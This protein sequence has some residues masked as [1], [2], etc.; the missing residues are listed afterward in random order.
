MRD[1]IRLVAQIAVTTE[2]IRYVTEHFIQTT[3][4]KRNAT[5]PMLFQMTDPQRSPVRVSLMHCAELLSG[6]ASRLQL[7]WRPGGW[8]SLAS[9]AVSNPVDAK[10]FRDGIVTVSAWLFERHQRP[11]STE[12]LRLVALGD[13]RRSEES[14]VEI[15]NQFKFTR[16]GN[17]R[18]ICCVP[19]GVRRWWRKSPAELLSPRM[20]CLMFRTAQQYS[21]A[22]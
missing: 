2:P 22:P 6:R 7:V 14:R 5:Q 12:P 10:R 11:F 13:P 8:D 3:S 21:A 16:E 18:L 19:W 15:V 17:N 20:A 4:E 1:D 9:W